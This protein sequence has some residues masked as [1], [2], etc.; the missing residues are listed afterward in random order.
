MKAPAGFHGW[1]NLKSQEQRQGDLGGD[2]MFMK[3]VMA[4]PVW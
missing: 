3:E 1:M 2:E 4:V